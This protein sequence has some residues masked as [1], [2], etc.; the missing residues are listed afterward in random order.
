MSVIAL[1]MVGV[2]NCATTAM[3]RTGVTVERDG[4]SIQM[5][6]RVQVNFTVVAPLSY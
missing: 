1:L 4:L 6:K 3:D 2:I 5:G